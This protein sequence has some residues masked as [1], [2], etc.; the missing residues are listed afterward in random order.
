[1]V[2]ENISRPDA[3]NVASRPLSLGGEINQLVDVLPGLSGVLGVAVGHVSLLLGAVL[4]L[5]LLGLGSVLSIELLKRGLG[6]LQGLLVLLLRLL[7][8]LLEQLLLLLLPLS[9]SLGGRVH[10]LNGGVGINI[11]R[12]GL[13]VRLLISKKERQ[14]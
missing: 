6:L 7:V 4:L 12:L 14:R 9:H 13:V 5:P 1:M 2:K 10:R 8:L 3:R 11:L